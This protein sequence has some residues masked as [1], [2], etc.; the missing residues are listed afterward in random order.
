MFE[1]FFA[2]G[3]AAAVLLMDYPGIKQKAIRLAN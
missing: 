3:C 2:N 1:K